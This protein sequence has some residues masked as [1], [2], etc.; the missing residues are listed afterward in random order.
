MAASA[1]VVGYSGSLLELLSDEAA[2]SDEEGS[3]SVGE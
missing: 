1:G 3:S 2:K